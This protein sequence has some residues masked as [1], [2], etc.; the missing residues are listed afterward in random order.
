MNNYFETSLA[1]KDAQKH[2]VANSAHYLNIGTYATRSVIGLSH[3]HSGGPGKIPSPQTPQLQLAVMCGY[4]GNK[5]QWECGTGTEANRKIYSIPSLP[6]T[7]NSA[8]NAP[9]SD[10]E[11][12]SS[13]R[14]IAIMGVDA[15]HWRRQ[16]TKGGGNHPQKYFRAFTK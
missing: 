2:L 12:K 8:Q 5:E 6:Y 14:S 4:A 7:S 16:G 11:L 10:W 9:G 1:G 13:P 3:S 15:M